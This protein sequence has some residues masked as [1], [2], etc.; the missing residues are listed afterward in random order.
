MY[1]KYCGSKITKDSSFCNK[2][3]KK[4]L[5][6]KENK[7][8][9]PIKKN[10]NNKNKNII[11]I[12]VFVLFILVII[13]GVIAG[14]KQKQEREYKENVE[15]QIED[16][17]GK[18]F[19]F[20]FNVIMNSAD[21]ETIGNDISTY[22]YNYIYKGKYKNPND[23][24]NKAIDKNKKLKK[25]IEETDERIKQ[26]Y[27]DVLVYPSECIHCEEIKNDI[28]DVYESYNKFYSSILYASGTYNDF[29]S[30]F[31][32]S[33]TE[34]NNKTQSLSSKLQVYKD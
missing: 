22:W 10:N 14:N 6:E 20:N 11:T 26:L 1:C 2:C 32:K 30:A 25:S 27:K 8:T 31:S 15:K 4:V 21:L 16:F 18:A 5:N 29:Q 12:I 3:G 24:I 23:A 19:G 7:I 28:D 33:D 13:A 9:K 34:V 17:Y